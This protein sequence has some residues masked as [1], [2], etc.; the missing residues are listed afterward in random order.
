MAAS[1]ETAEKVD[2]ARCFVRVNGRRPEGF[3]EFEF[4]IGEPDLFVELVLNQ[5]AFDEFC[6]RMA[7]LAL[8]P[9]DGTEA[10]G[11]WDWRLADARSQRFRHLR[12]ASSSTNQEP[13]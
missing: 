12:P 7:P 9:R 13:S 5:A 11:D 3:I 1:Q 8:P 2:V 6:A 4:A 10:V